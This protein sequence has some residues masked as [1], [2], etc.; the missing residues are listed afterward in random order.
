M[1][2]LFLASALPILLWDRG[3]D[4]IDSLR[5]ASIPCIAAPA[6]TLKAWAGFGFCV[7]EAR[8]EQLQKIPPPG[9]KWRTRD[10]NTASATRAP[11]VDSNG[12]RFIYRP[13]A[14]YLYELPAGKAALAAAEAFAFGGQAYVRIA[15]EDLKPLGAMLSFLKSLPDAS[16]LKPVSDIAVLDNKS[17]WIPEAL[18]L[19]ARRNL[20]FRVITEPDPSAGLN[21]RIGS[22]EFPESEAANP[23]AVADKARRLLTDRKRSLRIYGEEVVLGRLEQGRGR[24]RV[25]LL[26][27]GSD[28]VEETRV[29]VRGNYQKVRLAVLD[30]ADVKP[31]DMVVQDGAIEFT[32]PVIGV[33]AVADLEASK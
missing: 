19:M 25:H 5:A 9:V 28:K 12:W 15:P 18:N 4:T 32:I 21:L 33:Y 13:E 1:L 3:P 23:A 31:E 24:A 27:Y 7:N 8:L 17:K 16:A 20:L 29:R 2:S 22:P 6:P 30:A 26:N 14:K 11:W 10:A